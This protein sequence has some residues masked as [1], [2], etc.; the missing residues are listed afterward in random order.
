MTASSCLMNIKTSLSWRRR[1]R[2][3][4]RNTQSLI[5]LYTKL[6]A[7]CDQQATVDGAQ[8]LCHV[9]HRHLGT[10]NFAAAGLNDNVFT[11]YS[12]SNPGYLVSCTLDNVGTI[13][14]SQT[15]SINFINATLLLPRFLVSLWLIFI[16]FLCA[17]LCINDLTGARCNIYISR[18]CYDVSV[19]LSVCDGSALWS[20]CMPGRGE[21]SSRA[22]L[23]TARPS[24]LYP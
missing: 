15:L 5:V 2:S 6:D 9:H 21:G 14:F 24:S 4:L 10:N 16:R 23:A 3:T 1:T 13:L 17:C 19:R 11:I 18:L 8:I 7:E 20:R 22:I 12:P